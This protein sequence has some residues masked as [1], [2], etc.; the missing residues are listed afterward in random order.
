M[1]FKAFTIGTWGEF[2]HAQMTVKTGGTWQDGVLFVTEH[3]QRADEAWM[4]LLPDDAMDL[5]NRI[6]E[7]YELNHVGRNRK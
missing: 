6:I 2:P 7:Y 1:R 3:H 5:A 4:Y